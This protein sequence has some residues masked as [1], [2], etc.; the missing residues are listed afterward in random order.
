MERAGHGYRGDVM[1][2][3]LSKRERRE[4]L[5]EDE[6]EDEALKVLKCLMFMFT[7]STGGLVIK[8]GKI[9]IGDIRMWSRP[10]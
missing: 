9:G 2:E 1:S 7:L 6:D 4:Y 3:M 5:N 8:A 10:Y